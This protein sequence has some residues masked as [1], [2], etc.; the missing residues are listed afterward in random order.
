[1]AENAARTLELEEEVRSR[2]LATQKETITKQLKVEKA[3]DQEY[4][5][6]PVLRELVPVPSMSNIGEEWRDH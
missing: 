4:V 3:K 2:L 6:H 5:W 1:M